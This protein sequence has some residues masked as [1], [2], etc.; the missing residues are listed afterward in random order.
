MDIRH[1]RRVLRKFEQVTSF[2]ANLCCLGVTV[3]QCHAL[4]EIEYLG[5]ATIGTLAEQL[6]LD[7][8]TLSRTVDS[9]VKQGL[10]ER[11]P[12]PQDRRYMIVRLSP[13]GKQTCDAIN[14]SND[15]FYRQ[16]IASF[17]EARRDDLLEAI[18]L[19]VSAIRD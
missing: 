6:N 10:V 15:E 18:Q 19:F 14:E 2:Q 3:P 9:L 7:K 12:D 1:F 4:L 16:I 13:Q 17:P 5:E 8:S 11:L